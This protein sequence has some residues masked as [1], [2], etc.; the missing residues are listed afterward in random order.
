MTL[1]ANL[2]WEVQN[3]CLGAR[4]QYGASE[5]NIRS[6]TMTG[7][8]Q[9]RVFATTYMDAHHRTHSLLGNEGGEFCDSPSK[10][11]Q[12]K[13]RHL[14]PHPPLSQPADLLPDIPPSPPSIV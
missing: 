14:H 9:P 4:D 5:R 6:S 12:N 11:S 1:I 3:P 7:G 8:F 13:K 10:W 2:L